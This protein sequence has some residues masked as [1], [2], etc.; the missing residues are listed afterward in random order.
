[1]VSLTSTCPTRKHEKTPKIREKKKQGGREN[2]CIREQQQI[3]ERVGPQG[4]RKPHTP[5]EFS[6][7]YPHRWARLCQKGLMMDKG[8]MQ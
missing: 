8:K 4:V 6:I 5:R 2:N 1:M 3:Q 7:K